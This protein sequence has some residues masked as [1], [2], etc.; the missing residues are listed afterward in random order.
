VK[1]LISSFLFP[2]WCCFNQ[3]RVGLVHDLVKN[4][5]FSLAKPDG[6]YQLVIFSLAIFSSFHH[7]SP[8]SLLVC[9]NSL[10]NLS[11]SLL[12]FSI[13]QWLIFDSAFTIFRSMGL[14]S[15]QR[16]IFFFLKSDYHESSWETLLLR[17]CILR[18]PFFACYGFSRRNADRAE[19]IGVLT[20]SS[21]FVSNLEFSL[22]IWGWTRRLDSNNPQSEFEELKRLSTVR[23]ELSLSQYISDLS[24]YCRKKNPRL[25]IFLS[26]LFI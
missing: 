11:T 24:F 26:N 16:R 20:Q 9:H 8:D 13:V 18:C 2:F 22:D 21:S 17:F 4:L 12:F 1:D 3:R 23:T 6:L 14:A 10:K 25:I 7:A 5:Y 15:F 19:Y